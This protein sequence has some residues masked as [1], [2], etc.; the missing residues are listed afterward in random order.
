MRV[1]KLY[2]ILSNYGAFMLVDDNR[3]VYTN[4]KIKQERGKPLRIS[5]SNK[6]GLRH[7]KIE[8]ISRSTYYCYLHIY[9]IDILSIL[10]VIK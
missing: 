5:S 4:L 7:N 6:I 3:M 2:K 8:Y 10:K 1:E 9:K